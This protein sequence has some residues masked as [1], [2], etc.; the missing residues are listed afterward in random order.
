LDVPKPFYGPCHGGPYDK[1][2][3]VHHEAVRRIAFSTSTG[4]AL[5]ALVAS[6]DPDVEFGEY[7]WTG[8]AW[9][10]VG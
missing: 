2:N 1:R 3:L 6:D 8:K 4:K 5:P 9:L 7:H 10:W